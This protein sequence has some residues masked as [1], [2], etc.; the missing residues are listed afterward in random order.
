MS[1][2]TLL[3]NNAIVRNASVGNTPPHGPLKTGE[4]PLVQV[5]QPPGGP[6]IQEGQQKP[7]TILPP[8]DADSA[9]RTGGLPMVKVKMTDGK[10]KL[11][12]GIDEKVVIRDSKHGAVTAGALPMIQIKMDGGKPVQTNPNVVGAG[13]QI[14][15]APPVLSAPRVARAASLNQGYVATPTALATVPSHGY[16]A[17]A[18]VPATSQVRIARVAAPQAPQVALPPVPEFTTDELMLNRHLADKYL[19]DLLAA[20]ETP[21]EP[22]AEAPVVSEAIQFAKEMIEKI[23]EALVATAVRAEAAALAAQA[24]VAVVPA[25]PT[26]AAAASASIAPTP[27]VSHVAGRVGARSFSLAGSRSQRNSAMA[28]RRTARSG[29]PLPTVIVKMDGQRASVQNQAE[30]AQAKAALEAQPAPEANLAPEAAAST[31]PQG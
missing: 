5:R 12:D 26:V 22:S 1:D 21:I 3:R 7:V 25:M 29:P 30:I 15:A 11:E 24:P 10:A 2:V 14:P 13:P 23:D 9:V 17:R 19:A 20:V 16:V 4:L 18:A 6:Q 31:D 27:S 8:K 28:P